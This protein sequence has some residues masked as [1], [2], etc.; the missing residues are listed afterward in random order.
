MNRLAFLRLTQTCT[1]ILDSIYKE[2][3]GADENTIQ[4]LQGP[5]QG[6]ERQVIE[7]FDLSGSIYEL[8]YVADHSRNSYPS[9]RHRST[10]HFSGDTRHG[11]IR[12]R[13]L[14]DATTRF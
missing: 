5:I 10:L 12:T 1:T 14:Q 8:T 2:L 11:K 6:L 13:R 7:L 4:E 9:L 3:E